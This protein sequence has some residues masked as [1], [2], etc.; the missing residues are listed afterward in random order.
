MR[1]EKPRQCYL[2][3]HA[4]N[5]EEG[6]NSYPIGMAGTLTLEPNDNTVKYSAAS[7]ALTPHC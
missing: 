5:L 2:P 3:K 1:T 6:G 7:G 4:E